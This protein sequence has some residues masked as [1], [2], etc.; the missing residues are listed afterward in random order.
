ML[1]HDNYSSLS[2]YPT[3]NKSS[4]AKVGTDTM[5]QKWVPVGRSFFFSTMMKITSSS[6]NPILPNIILFCDA[7]RTASTA[8]VFL[9]DLKSFDYAFR[10]LS[11]CCSS[12]STEGCIRYKTS[13]STEPVHGPR[14]GP[15]KIHTALVITA[16]MARTLEFILCRQPTGR[17][18][19]VGALGKNGVDALFFAN[20]PDPKFLNIFFA[21]LTKRIVAG[22]SRLES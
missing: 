11:G 20:N 7:M 4:P 3:F 6:G 18:P 19:E 14:S 17:A 12:G 13:L 15:L 8:P 16:S 5:S 21:H 22:K 1:H 2:L 10:T 9:P